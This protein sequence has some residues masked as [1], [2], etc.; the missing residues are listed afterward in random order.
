MFKIYNYPKITN[1]FKNWNDNMNLKKDLC[2]KLDGN[3][4]MSKAIPSSQKKQ[5]PH[6]LHNTI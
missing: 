1:N 5:V 2:Q 3:Y 6:T 4:I